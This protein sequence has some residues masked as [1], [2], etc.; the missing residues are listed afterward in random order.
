MAL[1]N[2]SYENILNVH[3]ELNNLQI[4]ELFTN[5]NFLK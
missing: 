5:L 2:Y 4:K 1:C 3:L